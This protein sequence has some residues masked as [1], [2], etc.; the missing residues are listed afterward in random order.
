MSLIGTQQE[1][2][3][4]LVHRNAADEASKYITQDA[5]LKIV[6]DTR[7]SKNKMQHAIGCEYIH[8]VV[9]GGQFTV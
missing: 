5:H 2:R 8:T 9:N 1:H 7:S 6:H 3:H 4:Q